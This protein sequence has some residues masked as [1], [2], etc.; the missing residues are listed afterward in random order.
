MP[1]L[2][3]WWQGFFLVGSDITIDVNIE[4]SAVILEVDIASAVTLEVDITAQT[5]GNLDINLAASAITLNVNLEAQTAN[6][7]ISFA[8]QA[9]AVFD[10]AKWFAH[11]AEQVFVTG[12]A[13]IATGGAGTVGTRT[14]PAGK[15]FFIVGSGYG[16]EGGSAPPYGS[17][18]TIQL[19]AV[20][21]IRVGSQA[22]M[23]VIFD[24]PIRATAGQVVTQSVYQASGG[25]L[26]CRASFWGYD[27]DA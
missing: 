24:T 12:S 7:D 8:D 23:A 18:L 1:D 15:V 22:G 16:F 3:D 20:V 2:P 10:A 27:E 4:A 14:V 25:N 5:V 6:I 26:T 19:D 17:V 21:T 9:V 11:Q 13:T